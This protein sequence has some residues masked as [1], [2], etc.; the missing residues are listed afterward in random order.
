MAQST[1]R[2][3]AYHTH[4]LD[5][6][7]Y[8]DRY[9]FD[10]MIARTDPAL[11]DFELDIGNTIAAG[12]DPLPHLL[13][14]GSR[15]PLAHL[16]DWKGPYQPVTWDIPASA[17]IGEG[18]IAFGPIMAA[19]QKAGTSHAFIEEEAVTAAEVI[20]TIGRSYRYLKGLESS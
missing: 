19:M 11:V 10:E 13:A 9:G 4:G 18:T 14:P 1:G 7:R 20:A 8:G 16:K 3:F 6:R 15:I 2:R 17:P 12:A 5:F